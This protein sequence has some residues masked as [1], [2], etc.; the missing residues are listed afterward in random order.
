[1]YD[2]DVWYNGSIIGNL[3]ADNDMQAQVKVDLTYATGL[4]GKP[5]AVRS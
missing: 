3:K 4:F 1:M 2:Y 5:T